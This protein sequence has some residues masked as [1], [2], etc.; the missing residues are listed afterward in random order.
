[1]DAA[2]KY[3]GSNTCMGAKKLCLVIKI[4]MPQKLNHILG[5]QFCLFSHV[6]QCCLARVLGPQDGEPPLFGCSSLGRKE[7]DGRPGK[8]RCAGARGRT[9]QVARDV[10]GD[11]PV[12]SRCFP[13]LVFPHLIIFGFPWWLSPMSMKLLSCPMVFSPC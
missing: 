10:K 4:P 3:P 8:G 2:A 5:T 11:L 6:S 9:I 12:A 13:M 1:M 7:G